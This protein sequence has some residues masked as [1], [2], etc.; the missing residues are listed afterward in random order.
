MLNLTLFILLISLCL[1]HAFVAHDSLF[2]FCDVKLGKVS[3]VAPVA[4]AHKGD[5]VLGVSSCQE[6]ESI[7]V[8]RG[9]IQFLVFQVSD[10]SHLGSEPLSFGN[11][12]INFHPHTHLPIVRS[13]TI[14]E[15]PAIHVKVGDYII[16]HR[17]ETLLIEAIHTKVYTEGYYIKT[18]TPY[19]VIDG[20]VVEINPSFDNMVYPKNP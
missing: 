1:C 3:H 17:G 19:N 8:I 15:M 20:I 11:G 12:D 10:A 7:I 2:I 4:L 16:M 14:M 18:A 13:E 9:K 5:F 6:I